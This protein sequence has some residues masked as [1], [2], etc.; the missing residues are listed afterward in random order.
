MSNYQTARNG[1][2]ERF[3]PGLKLGAGDVNQVADSLIA[4]KRFLADVIGGE[5]IY[6]GGASSLTDVSAGTYPAVKVAIAD[7]S[8][9][10]WFYET[11]AAQTITF[12][13][14]TATS[15]VL[16]AVPVTLSGVT[17]AA[18][19]GSLSAIKFVADASTATAPAH[20]LIV[21]TGAIAS[22]AFT[23]FTK[24]GA[25]GTPLISSGGSSGGVPTTR[26]IYTTSPLAGGGTLASDLTLTVGAAS[27]SAA[28]VVELAPSGSTTSGLAVQA[29]DTRL[30]NVAHASGLTTGK[31]V[32]ASASNTLQSANLGDL[33]TAGDNV[34]VTSNTTTGGVTIAATAS[35]SGGVPT[36]RSVATTAPLTGGGTLASDLTLAVSAATTSASGVVTLAADGGT[37]GVVQGSDTR[38]TNSRTPT[39]HASTHAIGGTDALPAA[40][41]SAAG[42]VKLAADSAT[43]TGVAVQASDTRLANV[44]HTGTA[45]TFSAAQTFTL[46]PTVSALTASRLVATNSSKA[47]ASASLADYITAGSNVTVTANSSTGGVTIAS[48]ASGTTGL[49]ASD[50]ATY[51]TATDSSVT[52]T[53]NGTSGISIAAT[54]SGS[55]VPTTRSIT[56]TSPLTG[57]GTL[58]ADLTLAVSSATTSAAGVVTLAA[59]GASTSG[60]VVQATDSRLSNARTPTSHASTHNYGGSDAL[61]TGS[62]LN[63]GIVKLASNGATTTGLAVQASDDRLVS[64]AHTN[65]S[66]TF[67]STQT[68][69]SAVVSGLTASRLVGTNSTKSLASVNLADYITAGSNMTV[70]DNGS[71]GV[72][73]AST[74]S[75][76]G[77]L[78][79]SDLATYIVGTD[80]QITV[81]NNTTAGVTL[82]LPAD[83]SAGTYTGTSAYAALSPNQTSLYLSM[84]GGTNAAISHYYDGGYLQVSTGRLTTTRTAVQLVSSTYSTDPGSLKVITPSS[85][86]AVTAMKVFGTY[87][88][89]PALATN[90]S[91][92]WTFGTY[93]TSGPAYKSC[94]AWI[95]VTIAGTTLYIPAATSSQMTTNS[96]LTTYT[97]YES[98]LQAVTGGTTAPADGTASSTTGTIGSASVL[99]P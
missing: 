3:T 86:G 70:T 52:I 47:L 85:S 87:T 57:G 43:T 98:A 67:A 88:Y 91:Y 32:S 41:T 23:S 28:G 51:V 62:E 22:S 59:S 77:G 37:S 8:G 38:L 96:N 56:T 14:T 49:S 36:T 16:Y 10:M 46:A 42:L 80:S 76:S 18:A 9:V 12:N 89:A 60:A 24:A 26:H 39:A 4:A 72:T 50:L 2:A 73:L 33:V 65:A 1:L 11:T 99:T 5:G 84:H 30:A 61:L 31:L 78:S 54:G 6:D 45:Q 7:D 35:G 83:I 82:S 44:A 34:T 79:A 58:A 66:N 13:T 20:S 40:T 69:A 81:T 53:N 17:P 25:P 97:G 21:G 55:G 19:D 71:G 94:D 29:S 74:A 27:E 93:T 15:G 64:V 75:G 90:D 63:Y 68:F 95:G 92:P 48:T